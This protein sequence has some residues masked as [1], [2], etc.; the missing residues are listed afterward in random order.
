MKLSHEIAA[1][2]LA[3]ILFLLIVAPAAAEPGSALEQ[4]G[5]NF[6]RRVFRLEIRSA[7]PSNS[8]DLSRNHF[9]PS[10]EQ[11]LRI[12]GDV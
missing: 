2:F 7:I 8:L 3:L 12:A 6:Q 11:R 5:W 10:S 4:A 1:A 9:T